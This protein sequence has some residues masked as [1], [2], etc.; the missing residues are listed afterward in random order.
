MRK[1]VIV[2]AAVVVGIVGG[3]ITLSSCK[4]VG[5]GEVGVVWTMKNGVQD[6]ILTPGLHFESPWTKVKTYPV[7]QQQLILS[8]NPSDYGKKE[9]EDWHV[10]APADGGMVKLNMTVNYNFIADRVTQLYTKFNGMDGDSIVDSMVQNSIIA[11]IKEVTP[12][13]TVMDI[14]SDKRAE[15]SKSITEYLNN[16]LTEEYGINVASALIIDVQ[17]DDTLQAKIQAKEQAKQD[18]E[19]AEPDRKTA[20]AQAEVSKVNAE[21]DAEVQKIKAEAE[22][23][24]TRIAAQAEADANAM[25]NNSITEDLI[26]MKEAEARLKHG[27]VTVQG[28]QAVVTDK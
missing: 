26:R 11:Y 19:K 23:E 18:A 9:H 21:A 7:S 13:Y 28:A 15:V 25:I 2:I 14:Y 10:D 6:E 3:V 8:N 5:Q 20:A 16:R 1:A 22:A 27:W 12:E 17:L 24:K 4:H